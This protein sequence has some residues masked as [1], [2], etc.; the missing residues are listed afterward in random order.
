MTTST[1]EV[2]SLEPSE[3]GTREYW[4]NVYAREITNHTDDHDDEG[5]NWFDE[6]SAEERVI[7]KLESIAERGILHKSGEGASRILDLG[8]GNGHMLFAL[9]EPNEDDLEPWTGDMVGVDYSVPSID[10]AR[11]IASQRQIEPSIQFETCDLLCEEPGEWLQGGFD[12]V[13]D[14]GTFDAISLMPQ[15]GEVHTCDV[16]FN[17]V[18]KLVKPG[19]LLAITSC[20]WTKAELL[21]W[22]SHS[23]QQTGLQYF[24]E[25]QYQTFS[26][27]G[28]TGSSIVSLIFRRAPT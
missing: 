8:T 6:Y 23:S 13:L 11:Q 5:T 15:S 19:G 9:R 26:F 25:A 17:Q 14:K 18:V 16:Y 10:L 21:T 28:M 1:T 3:L 27:G 22:L 12:L 2:T 7:D 24:D 20:N 4:D